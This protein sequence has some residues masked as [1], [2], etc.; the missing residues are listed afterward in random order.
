M[1]E[2]IF[3]PQSEVSE[4]FY[5]I[6]AIKNIP[7]WYSKTTPYGKDKTAK[8]NNTDINLTVKKCM[9]VF[10]SLTMGYIIKTHVD[11]YVSQNENQSMAFNWPSGDNPIGFHPIRQAEKYPEASGNFIFKYNS[12]WSIKT[13]SGVSCLFVAPMHNPNSIFTILPGV[14]DTDKYILPVNFPLFFNNTSFEGM[15]PAGT[16]VCQVIPF[17]RSEFKMKI[18]KDKNKKEIEKMSAAFNFRWFGEYKN[19]NWKRKRFL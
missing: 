11:I 4:E 1:S 6:P 5:P 15:I 9:P 8:V 14:V 12:P 7:D 13:K 18:G 2:I 19:K 17:Q 16:D 10:D 3:T